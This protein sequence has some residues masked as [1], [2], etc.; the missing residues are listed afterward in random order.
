MKTHELRLTTD[1]LYQLNLIVD[2]FQPVCHLI[3]SYDGPNLKLDTFIVSESDP[4]ILVANIFRNNFSMQFEYH[5]KNLSVDFVFLKQNERLLHFKTFEEG[6]AR[7]VLSDSISNLIETELLKS[8]T[9]YLYNVEASEIEQAIKD[10]KLQEAQDKAYKKV[11]QG[12]FNILLKAGPEQGFSE[13]FVRKLNLICQL[14]T[15]NQAPEFV[16]KQQL[17][18]E[19][20]QNDYS[21]YFS[22]RKE[23]SGHYNMSHEL[24][25]DLK[26]YY[27]G[28]I[29][30]N[31]DTNYS[32]A[33]VSIYAPK[34]KEL[35]L[36][37][38]EI[39]GGVI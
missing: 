4:T 3:S 16:Y 28:S 10:R 38:F 1:F 7:I 18:F 20:L 30:I 21:V 14:I 11:K 15:H 2:I 37:I 26:I 23:Y 35:E 34:T 19:L 39:T 24:V 12:E 36:K 5:Q 27:K 31:A 9:P 29:L 17:K 25:I 6:A 33:R 22:E 32:T 8:F 13:R